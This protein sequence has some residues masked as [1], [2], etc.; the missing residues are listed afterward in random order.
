MTKLKL[1]RMYCVEEDF[2]MLMENGARQLQEAG[3]S[4]VLDTFNSDHDDW[5][6]WKGPYWFPV[7][8][9]PS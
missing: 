3:L 6:W 8:D 4:I 2:G 7:V 9:E 1:V 5:Q